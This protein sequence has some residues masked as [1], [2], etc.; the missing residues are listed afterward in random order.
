MTMLLPHFELRT[1][2][3]IIMEAGWNGIFFILSCYI[4]DTVTGGFFD[5]Y[6]RGF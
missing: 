5:S 1:V 3:V 6:L 4:Q 2:M